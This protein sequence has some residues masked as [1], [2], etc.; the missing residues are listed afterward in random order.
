MGGFSSLQEGEEEKHMR[1]MILVMFMVG[2]I[3][4]LVFS[5]GW[6][7]GALAKDPIELSILF[8]GPAPVFETKV[9]KEFFVN[10]VNERAKGELK[11]I[12][13]N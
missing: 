8:F 12:V 1:R 11:I 9:V 7:S 5:V 10:K 13:Y 2:S 3:I 4:S 6:E